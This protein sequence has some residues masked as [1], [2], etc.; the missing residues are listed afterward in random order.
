MDEVAG[1]SQVHDL[2]IW[3]V[4]PGY[5][6]LSAHVV[7]DDQRLTDAQWIQENLRL[8]LARR[9]GIRHTTVQFECANCG[10]GLTTCTNGH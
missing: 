8:T 4:S 5:V 3:T 2:H 10:Q 1:V 6:A 7:L 9:F